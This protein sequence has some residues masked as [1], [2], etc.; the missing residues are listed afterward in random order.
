MCFPLALYITTLDQYGLDNIDVRLRLELLAHAWVLNTGVTDG[1]KYRI[2]VAYAKLWVT[3][4]VPYP[5]TYLA[6]NSSLLASPDPVSYTFK[7]TIS[8]T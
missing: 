8:K 4:D 1:T 3:L 5:S 6:L 7:R 2:H